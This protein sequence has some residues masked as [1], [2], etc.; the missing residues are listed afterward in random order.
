MGRT[1]ESWASE[2]CQKGQQRE[3]CRMEL[4]EQVVEQVGCRECVM[5]WALDGEPGK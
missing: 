4:G 2:K 3:E 1:L 5:G